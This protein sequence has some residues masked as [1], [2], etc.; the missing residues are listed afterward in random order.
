MNTRITIKKLLAILAFSFIAVAV[1]AE[2]PVSKSFFGGIAI[3]GHDTVAY[4]NIEESDPHKAAKGSKTWKAKWKGATWLFTTE[5]DRDLFAAD[6]ER[7]APAYNGHCANA[8]SLGE[9]LLKTDGTHWQIFDDQLYTFYA[10]HGRDRWLAGD[11]KEYKIA[12]DK[13]WKEI[14]NK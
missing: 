8:L 3:E 12:A 11:F 5:S 14:I 4:H 6:P 1:Q 2:E 9:G 7:Y 10:A 13:A